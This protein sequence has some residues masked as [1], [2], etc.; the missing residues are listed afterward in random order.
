MINSQPEEVTQ[1][2]G[3]RNRN[4]GLG[5]ECLETGVWP[6]EEEDVAGHQGWACRTGVVSGCL[7]ASWILSFHFRWL[8]LA[9]MA[10]E[11]TS[12]EVSVGWP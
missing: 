5:T 1:E 9:A 12:P 3:P 2:E 7:Q 8:T 11:S 10:M 6:T 4:F